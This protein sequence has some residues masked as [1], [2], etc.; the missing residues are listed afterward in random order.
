MKRFNK[1]F[2]A[3]S[4][5]L[6][7]SQA[8]AAGFQL[9]SQSATGLG[10]AMAGDAVIADN[11]SVLSRNPA[12]MALFKD[13]AV[14]LGIT[15]ADVDV[16]VD[17][18]SS[19]TTNFG[20]DDSAGSGK[21]IPNAYYIQPINES[22]AMGFAAFSNFGTGTDTS[23]ITDDT[24]AT[25]QAPIDLLGE[26]EITSVDF[27]A[28]VSYRFNEY[29]SFG[30]GV[31][32]VYGTGKLTRNGPFYAAGAVDYYVADVE[33]SGWGVGGIAGLV[34]E[35][36]D[37]NRIGLSYRY[38]P[39]IKANGDTIERLGVSYDQIEIPLPN[40]AQLGGFHQITE[41]FALSYTVQYTQWGEFD[42]LTL[43]DSDVNGSDAILKEYQWDDSWLFSI[44]GTYD[45]NDTW[46][47]RIGYMYDQGVVGDLSSISIPD[48]DRN[49][50]TGGVSYHFNQKSSLDL[51]IAFVR[52]KKTD[53]TEYS[54]FVNLGTQTPITAT[55]T[56]N[57]VYYSMQY[58]YN[59]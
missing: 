4:I 59:F 52:G 26:T 35:I 16:S 15:Y 20:S 28:S 22:W 25:T 21:I 14:S 51:G 31:D 7:S 41:H 30:L 3:I 57:A 55:T 33:A 44:G 24:T 50:Y 42:K 48:S 49:W 43:L 39:T 34:Y 54:S 29:V 18:V 56:S 38:S 40:I 45:I 13:K 8:M 1:T 27:N 10:R 9:N 6:A 11:A 58:S 53:L 12:A 46:T 2:L 32:F 23:A 19:P 47:A 5:T 17:D 37:D 36:N